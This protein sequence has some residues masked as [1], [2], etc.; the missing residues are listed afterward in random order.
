MPMWCNS[1]TMSLSMVLLARIVSS[2]DIIP[3][4]TARL[5]SNLAQRIYHRN[6]QPECPGSNGHQATYQFPG[7]IQRSNKKN[8]SDRNVRPERN[9]C[10]IDTS[11]E[12][13]KSSKRN[14]PNMAEILEGNHEEM[15]RTRPAARRTRGKRSK[16]KRTTIA[17]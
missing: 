10:Q 11:G 8:I 6:P 1:S 14:Q 9:A 17:P 12:G 16:S 5:N 13:T 7:G 15:L 3:E 4:N 2:A